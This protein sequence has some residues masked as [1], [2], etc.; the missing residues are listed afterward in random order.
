MAYYRDARGEEIDLVVEKAIDPIAL[1]VKA[2]GTPP[3]HLE[4]RFRSL[5]AVLRSAPLPPRQVERRIV[6]AGGQRVVLEGIDILPWHDVDQV[7]WD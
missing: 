6:Y 4:P 1:E 5:E 2:S 7:R 3:L